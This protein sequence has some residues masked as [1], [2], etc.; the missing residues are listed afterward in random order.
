MGVR[1]FADFPL[2][3][4][5][6]RALEN[7]AMPV[8][9]EAIKWNKIFRGEV[10]E[11][12]ELLSKTNWD[13]KKGKILTAT[14]TTGIGA[15][16]KKCEDAFRAAK[17][18]EFVVGGRFPDE[19]E[20]LAK[21]NCVPFV[22]GAEMKKL[23]DDFK[24][25]AKLATDTGKELKKNPLIPTSTKKLID[26]IAAS[27]NLLMVFCN[28]NSLSGYLAKAIEDR[29]KEHDSKQLERAGYSLQQGKGMGTKALTAIAEIRKKLAGPNLD[30]EIVK[31][32]GP[33]LFKACRDMT[34]P[35]L[36]IVKSAK[37]GAKFENFK[38]SEITK[39]S[40]LLVPYGDGNE[41]TL[42]GLDKDAI[43]AKLT[44]VGK[45]AQAYE[46]LVAPLEH[47]G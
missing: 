25:L 8:S 27:A 28:T 3:T 18:G 11:W 40:K 10:L 31:S 7:Q 6:L 14:K 19:T 24:D 44:L 32:C 42:E 21:A 12:P 38:E 46:L 22:N 41:A 26:E 2:Y 33:L 23:H 39:L 47:V 36:N 17:M 1:L 15:A 45:F 35:L 20:A 43:E 5:P 34:Q 37:A 16:L 4:T 30:P 29:N 9:L 13:Q